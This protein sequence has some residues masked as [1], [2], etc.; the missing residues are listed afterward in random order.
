MKKLTAILLTLAVVL[1]FAITVNAD[2]KKATINDALE[3]LMYLAGMDSN[4]TPGSTIDDALDILIYLAG[5]EIINDDF[6]TISK[7]NIVHTNR[8][9]YS[10]LQQLTDPLWGIQLIVV[11]EFVE[12]TEANFRMWFNDALQK[13][14]PFFA[15]AFNKIRITEVLQGDAEV[16]D[17]IPIVQRYAFN[18]AQGEL[19]TWDELTPMNKGDQWI[20]FLLYDSYVGAYEPAGFSDGRYPL[21]TPAITESLSSRAFAQIETADLGVLNRSDFNFDLYAEILDHFDIAPRDWVN[22]GRASDAKLIEIV[23]RQTS[24]LCAE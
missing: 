5:L 20:M 15:D 6:A 1:S 17:I 23:Q 10:S 19:V 8:V 24:T 4:A 3:I 18:R 12:E 21:P 7:V 16:G 14:T 11:G 13:D 2:N 22:P 9:V